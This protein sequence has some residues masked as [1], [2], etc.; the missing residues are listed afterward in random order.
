MIYIYRY[1]VYQTN[2]KAFD[3]DFQIEISPDN[4]DIDYYIEIFNSPDLHYWYYLIRSKAFLENQDMITWYFTV[5]DKPFKETVKPY[6]VVAHKDVNGVQNVD[7]FPRYFK[8]TRKLK[9]EPNLFGLD[10][11]DLLTNKLGKSPYS[12]KLLYRNCLQ[13]QYPKNHKSLIL[14]DINP[15]FS[16]NRINQEKLLPVD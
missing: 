8:N 13:T 5:T 14:S 4:D 16:Q 2:T 11:L 7:V 6:L 12:R 1:I 3:K 15:D 10:N 9:I